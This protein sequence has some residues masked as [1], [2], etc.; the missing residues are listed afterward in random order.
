MEIFNVIDIDKN[1]S[2]I[3]FDE[4]V[5]EAELRRNQSIS[6]GMLFNAFKV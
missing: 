5:R 4:F 2:F 6:T 1:K 3:S